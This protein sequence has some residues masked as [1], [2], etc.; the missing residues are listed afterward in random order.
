MIVNMDKFVKLDETREMKIL[1]NGKIVVVKPLDHSIVVP[2]FCSVCTFPMKTSDDSAAYKMYSCCDRCGLR[3][4]SGNKEK[5]AEGWRPT[6]DE[7]LEY[8][9]ERELLAKPL[10]NLK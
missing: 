3:F 9:E 4:A 7:L 2:L 6:E 10:L 8:K 5:W 1:N